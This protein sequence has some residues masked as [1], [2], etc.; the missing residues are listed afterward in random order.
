MPE[1][2][3][4]PPLRLKGNGMSNLSDLAPVYQTDFFISS[5]IEGLRVKLPRQCKCGCRMFVTGPGKA[6]HAASLLCASCSRHSGWL[7]GE[8]AR[9]LQ[10]IVETFGKPTE[11]I[12]VRQ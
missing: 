7:S 11:A 12:E 3:E 5:P 10:K 6:T 8:S 9:F 2:A 1:E 4:Q